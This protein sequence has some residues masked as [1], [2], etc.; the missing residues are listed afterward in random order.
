[1]QQDEIKA[2]INSMQI[3]IEDHEKMFDIALQD[4]RQL[5]HARQLY[6]DIKN[7]EARIAELKLLQVEQ[8]P[9]KNV[10]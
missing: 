1:M 9:D 7:L 10:D 4:P 2:E 8:D 3:Q 5:G 6:K